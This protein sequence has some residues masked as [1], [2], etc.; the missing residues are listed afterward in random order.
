MN[1][2]FYINR[3]SLILS[4]TVL[5]FFL[6][7]RAAATDSSSSI[8]SLK[9]ALTKL[10]DVDDNWIP[11][12]MKVG[13]RYLQKRPDSA[14]I[15]IKSA[16]N[17]AQAKNKTNEIGNCERLLGR[18]FFNQGLFQQSLRHHLEAQKYYT[19]KN[20]RQQEIA[21]NFLEMG[22]LYYYL[23]QF[24]KSEKS[25]YEALRI[26][27]RIHSLQGKANALGKLGH[28]Y[29]KKKNYL[30]AHY[31]QKEAL[32]IYQ[33]LN[34]KEGI[35]IILENIG[36]IYEDEEEYKKAYDY[37]IE[38]LQYNTTM[39]NHKAMISNYNNIGDIYRKKG[40]YPQALFYS[41]RALDEATVLSDLF[42]ISAA[43]KDLSK[44]Y[45]LMGD[46]KSAY[47]NLEKGRTIY[48]EIFNEEG[49][50]QLVLMQTLYDIDK[51]D[52]EI[53]LLEKESKYNYIIR[54]ALVIFI[55]LIVVSAFLIM[56]RQR[57]KIR[58]NNQIIEQNKRLYEQEQAL[59]KA[60][61]QNTLLKEKQLQSEIQVK[62]QELTS[63]ALHLIRKNKLLEDLKV[64]LEVI[65]KNGK[66]DPR[67]HVKSLIKKVDYS[68]IQDNEWDDFRKSF[69]QVHYDFMQGLR[70][71]CTDLSATELRLCALIKLNI[72]SKDIATMMGI[73]QDSLRVAR[74][75]LRKK[76]MLNHGDSLTVFIQNL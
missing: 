61:L 36:S 59:I 74:Y 31:Y 22:M 57:L 40:D 3:P 54:A 26:F 71:H 70:K 19:I 48:E 42:Q 6:I 12:N 43:Y 65:N 24:N 73:T 58:K 53:N 50:K 56:S 62:T 21:E 14:Y 29:E 47:E 44:T 13:E 7:T 1:S 60:E 30:T 41:N 33:K 72:S 37:F 63:N 8:D 64:D 34:D 76:L 69:E 51:K 20:N 28:M 2:F 45:N 9:N 35:A 25:Y 38:S 27:E 4:I 52:Q 49:T 18:V 17:A 67:K 15:F 32:K 16:L 46:Y 10:S 55:L 68:I 75:R 11:I 5:T 39:D 66:E 23:R